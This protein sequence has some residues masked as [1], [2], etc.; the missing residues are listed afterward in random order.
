[1]HSGGNQSWQIVGAGDF[2][3]D[4]MADLLWRE[5]SST[6]MLL[7]WQMK[8]PQILKS[9]TLRETTDLGWSVEWPR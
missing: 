8:G 6:G 4:G 2:N 9:V 3:G 7:Y 5:S 1:V